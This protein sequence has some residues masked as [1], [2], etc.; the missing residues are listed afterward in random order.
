VGN[1]HVTKVAQARIIPPD[2]CEL[3]RSPS[4]AVHAAL[5][6]GASHLARTRTWHFGGVKA[7]TEHV[8]ARLGF[9]R[10]ED[11]DLY[12]E[13]AEDFRH[14]AVVRGQAVMF[15]VRLVDLAVVYERRR[16]GMAERDFR[17][18]FQLM[19]KEVDRRPDWSVVALDDPVTFEQ[20]ATGVN[21]VNR[22][23][24][25]I[26][27]RELPKRP[28]SPILNALMRAGSELVTIDLRSEAGVDVE[29]ATVQELVR[30]ASGG[31][32]DVFAVGRGTESDAGGTQ[33]AWV[34]LNSAERVVHEVLLDPDSAEISEADL[35]RILATVPVDN[36][37]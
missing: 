19:L 33:K 25:R 17:S 14:E 7:S 29:G 31:R 36:P 35:L 20:W 1:N 3:Y 2:Q 9:E 24:F 12:D 21:S 32:G 4:E 15:A 5:L 11:T 6:A 10:E 22:F 13:Q 34:S 27:G 16:G 28:E 23:R 18:G 37:W 30:V 26:E 8:V